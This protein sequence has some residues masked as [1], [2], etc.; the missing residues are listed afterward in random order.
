MSQ[1]P[2][3]AV[4]T[5][6]LLAG[7]NGAD[8]TTASGVIIPP[9]IRFLN[10]DVIAAELAARDTPPPAWT[11]RLDGSCSLRSEN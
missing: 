10:A 2:T 3:E 11:W 9:G 4:P 1:E 7:P 6:L 8:K 5:V